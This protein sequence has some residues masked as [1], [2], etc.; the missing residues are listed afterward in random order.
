M[1]AKLGKVVIGAMAAGFAV[2]T[3]ALAPV[4]QADS[5]GK[6]WV[7][8]DVAKPG[9]DGWERL[10]TGQNPILVSVNAVKG[11]TIVKD[12]H[13]TSV[14]LKAYDGGA[15]PAVTECT[16]GGGSEGGGSGDL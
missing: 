16:A 9:T 1:N 14:V 5:Q 15:E 4:A 3:V 11:E 7:C 6:V 13:V 12:Q 10:Q 2:S 8:K